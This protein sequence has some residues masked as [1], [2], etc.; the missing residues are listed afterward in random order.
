MRKGFRA[1]SSHVSMLDA[2]H[3]ARGPVSRAVLEDRPRM[4]AGAVETHT[5][6]EAS[7]N[8]LK[9]VTVATP[10]RAMPN[11]GRGSQARHCSAWL[12]LIRSGAMPTNRRP[13]SSGSS[14][15]AFA[16]KSQP[17]ITRVKEAVAEIRTVAKESQLTT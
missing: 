14:T 7:I 13:S 17:A 10:L 8:N 12:T 2:T 4:I 11:A 1:R 5:S 6:L 16:W 15:P 9:Q 3:H